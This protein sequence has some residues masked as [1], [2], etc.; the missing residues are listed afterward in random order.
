[1]KKLQD[2]RKSLSYKRLSHKIKS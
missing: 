1:L 2:K